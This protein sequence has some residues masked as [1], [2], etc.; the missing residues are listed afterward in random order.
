M[1][2]SKILTFSLFIPV[3]LTTNL[4]IIQLLTRKIKAKHNDEGA[5]KLAVGIWLSIL[6]TAAT[7]ITTKS[8]SIFYETYD[9]IAIKPENLYPVLKICSI[10]TGLGLTWFIIWF[11]ITRVFSLFILGPRNESK[12]AEANNIAFFIVRGCIFLGFI[13]CL[14]PAFEALL[15]LFLPTVE[16]PFYH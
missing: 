10:F 11:Y 12:E 1:I 14:T 4:I 13:I 6:F 2:T 7:I 15:R 8:A 3:I 9:Q 16:I 5:L